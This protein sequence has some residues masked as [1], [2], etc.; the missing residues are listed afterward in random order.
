[1]LDGPFGADRYTGAAFDALIDIDRN[2]FAGVKFINRRRAGIDTFFFSTA[3]VII[4][5]DRDLFAFP[6]FD[7]HAVAFSGVVIV[8]LLVYNKKGIDNNLCFA[9]D[10]MRGL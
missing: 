8:C 5:L 10:G 4:H 9:T 3:C 1:V 6:D 2:G 7:I